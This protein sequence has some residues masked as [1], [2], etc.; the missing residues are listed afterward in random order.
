M[1]TCWFTIKGIN[2]SS[3][4][5]TKD[6]LSSINDVKENEENPIATHKTYAQ[7]AKSDNPIQSIALIY[8][9]CIKSKKQLFFSKN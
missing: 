2:E 8:L 6:K 9:N 5:G 3:N 7:V 4:S 1:Y